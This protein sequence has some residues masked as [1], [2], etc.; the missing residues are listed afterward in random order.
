[1]KKRIL[2]GVMVASAA[3][4]GGVGALDAV[5]NLL[6]SESML[7]LVSFVLQTPCTGLPDYPTQPPI[8]AKASGASAIEANFLTGLSGN[9]WVAAMT[10]PL[11]SGICDINQGATAEGIVI[12][13]DAV[14]VV[15]DGSLNGPAQ[16]IAITS[17]WRSVLRL[18]YA[19]M[20]PFGDSVFSRDCNSAARRALVNNWDSL[21]G[22]A[23]TGATCL[24]SHPS[25][26]GQ[27]AAGYDQ[28]NTIV[29]PG[30][31]HAFRR[32]EDSDATDVFLANLGLPRIDFL[33]RFN[34]DQRPPS[35]PTNST[36]LQT[37]VYRALANSPFCNVRR[38]NDA[39]PPVSR[40]GSVIPPMYHVG[41]PSGTTGLGLVPYDPVLGVSPRLLSP[42]Y[43][44]LQD[45]DPIR[46]RCIGR[47]VPL[48]SAPNLPQEQVCSA[49]GNL[50]L[51]LPISPPPALTAPERY[52]SVACNDTLPFA[53]GPAPRRPTGDP[54]R[55]PNGDVPQDGQ[56]LL[57]VDSFG[58]FNCLN[59]AQ[60][61]PVA[62]FDTDGNGSQFPDAP[63]TDGTAHADGRAYN[64]ILR[65]ADGQIRTI[66]RPD[67]MQVGQ[68][69]LVPMIGA[70]Y[71]IHSTRSGLVPPNH[72]RSCQRAQADDQIGC[73]VQLNPCSMG[74]A[75]MQAVNN[76]PGTISAPLD[77][78]APTTAAIQA[79]VSGGSTYPLAHKRYLHAPRGFENLLSSSPTV[80]NRDAEL[81][82]SKC[83]VGYSTLL[84]PPAGGG[85][86]HSFCEDFR[87]RGSCGS[88]EVDACANNPPG[89]PS[90][91]CDNGY[92]DGDEVGVDVCPSDRPTCNPATHRCQ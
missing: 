21:F 89:I 34:S 83:M 86:P 61:V 69:Q 72:T 14:H 82:F 78:I 1:M 91:A 12:G 24:D 51:V 54:V 38:P 35:V 13:L 85:T 5:P 20:G 80:P 50:G 25:V 10:V 41:V 64:L 87:Q 66:V 67:P 48:A 73:L 81:D 45:Q 59:N 40:S 19:G 92:R 31:R 55:C 56:C 70:Y 53:F 49:D 63:S 8:V 7:E 6:T 60:N 33:Q 22:G 18:V 36:A 11:T 62:L 9:Q 90:S 75:R 58:Q 42:Y 28:S 71:R 65:R 4:T 39:Y 88:T 29:E 23:S 57:P 2:A 30:L 76:N 26:P 37:S 68:T 16:G 27:G 79:L 52:P 77:N 3:S 32:S 74:Y 44:E 43:P 47:P 15:F 46:R 17:D 84:P